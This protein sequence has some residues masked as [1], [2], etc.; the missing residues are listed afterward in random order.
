VDKLSKQKEFLSE[1]TEY[2]LV[3]T[4]LIMRNE[5][6]KEL[7]RFRNPLSDK[8]IRTKILYRNCHSHSSVFFRKNVAMEFGG[9]SD[10]EAVRHI[11]DYDL[12][13]KMGTKGKIANL[14][15]YSVSFTLHPSA[16]SSKFK[17][18]QFRNQLA[19][20]RTYSP[21]LNFSPY[22]SYFLARVK[23]YLRL[24]AYTVFAGVVPNSLQNL[25]LRFYKK[26]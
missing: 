5:D 13:L 21:R 3:G 24:W 1:N 15:D 4:G 12:W 9:Y 6:G 18:I 25:I 17:L 23:S 14:P 19:L 26:A 22:D 10:S 7:F 16:I 8:E 11:E 2:V 20:I